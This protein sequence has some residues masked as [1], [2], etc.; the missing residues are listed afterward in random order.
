MAH[1]LRETKCCE[2]GQLSPESLKR[3]SAVPAP[4]QPSPVW[5]IP[6]KYPSRCFGQRRRL[7]DSA[8]R[9]LSLSPPFDMWGSFLTFR[10]SERQRTKGEAAVT[11]NADE[12][13]TKM[14]AALVQ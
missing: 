14:L 10:E 11:R 7:T 12:V 3:N 1:V 2:L 9:V 4:P 6:T 13:I 5:N 8:V